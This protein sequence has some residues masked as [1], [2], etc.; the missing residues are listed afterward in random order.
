MS[1]V[2]LGAEDIRTHLTEVAELLST[3]R[4]RHALIVVGGSLLALHGIRDATVDVDCV[5]RLDDEMRTAAARVARRHDLAPK[6]LN[7]HAAAFTPA[8]LREEDCDVL[9]DHRRLLVL[10]APLQQVFV[11]KLY[12]GRS[13]DFDDL[14]ALWPRATSAVLRKQ[15]ICSTRRT[16]TSCRT[17]SSLTTSDRS[18]GWRTA[19]RWA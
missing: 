4:K 8:T 10:G 7:D 9:L 17:R 16:R 3:M 14:V 18:P 11:M 13:L 15:R 2:P 6:W 12:A 5:E 1:D 19:E